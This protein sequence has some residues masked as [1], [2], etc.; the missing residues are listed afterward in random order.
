MKKFNKLILYVL[1]GIQ[2]FNF[3]P[4]KA[5]QNNT[6]DHAELVKKYTLAAEQ[7]DAE[8]QFNLGIMYSK[9]NKIIH[10]TMQNW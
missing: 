4:V 10:K 6:Q 8:A 7:G 1:G 9:H 5:Q 2:I 3:T